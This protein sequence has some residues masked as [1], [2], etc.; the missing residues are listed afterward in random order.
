MA[1]IMSMNYKLQ[2]IY[3][4]GWLMKVKENKKKNR[5]KIN[6]LISN[7]RITRKIRRIMI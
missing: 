6:K 5:K 7:E 2:L 3:E 4:Y 1:K